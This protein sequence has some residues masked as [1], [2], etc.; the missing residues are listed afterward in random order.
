FTDQVLQTLVSNPEVW[1]KT[2]LFHMYDE[3]D[4]FFDHVAPP[5]APPA[6]EGEFLTVHP[7]P[8]DADGV[9]GPIGLGFR[10]PF[11]VLS[12][13]ARGGRICPDTFD[14]TSQLR[15]LEERFGVKAPNIS[16]WRRGAV[17]NLTTTLDLGHT[18]TSLPDLPPTRD[19]PAYLA[20]KGCSNGDLL[21]VADDQ[22]PYPVPSIQHMPAQ[23][24]KSN[25][26]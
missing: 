21:E 1:S 8:A 6:T 10:V 18:D 5:V 7:L 19:D 23:E 11:M 4:G 9:A 15:F 14:H 20:S 12:P 3:N 13:F 22:P 24:P 25:G 16:A 17:G 26:H 2:V